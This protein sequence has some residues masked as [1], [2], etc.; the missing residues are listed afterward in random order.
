MNEFTSRQY[1]TDEVSR[2]IRRAL[3]LKRV[4]GISYQDFVDTAREIGL[5]PKTVETAIE[6]EQQAK[7]KKRSERYGLN[8]VRWDSTR[9]CG[10]T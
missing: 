1:D 7:K 5:D 2:I 6:Q 10:V 8:A 9:I 3:K 4:H